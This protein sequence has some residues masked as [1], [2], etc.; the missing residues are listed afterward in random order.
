MGGSMIVMAIIG[1]AAF[2]PAMGLVFEATRSM[3]MAV[4]LACCL[5]VA[6]YTFVGSPMR[7]PQGGHDYASATRS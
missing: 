2:T 6:Y 7:T 3:A 1:G 5:V 4:P